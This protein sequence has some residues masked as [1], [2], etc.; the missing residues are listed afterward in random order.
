M[1]IEFIKRLSPYTSVLPIIAKS[2]TLTSQQAS[3]LK[4]SILSELRANGIR[5][6]LFGKSASDILRQTSGDS[7]TAPFAISSAVASDSEN[8][9]ASVLMSADYVPPLVDTELKHLVDAVFDPDHLV[10][11]KHVTAKKY[12]AWRASQL[13]LSTMQSS[14]L[15]SN[16]FNSSPIRRPA[17]PV[18]STTASPALGSPSDSYQLAR[19]ADHTQR[20]ER[21]AKVR[22]SRWAHDLQK[23]LHTEKERYQRLARGERAIWLTE[24]LNECVSDGQIVPISTSK[25]DQRI[26]HGDIVDARDPCGLVKMQETLGQRVLV[27]CKVAGIGGIVGVV[28]V[29]VFRGGAIGHMNDFLFGKAVQG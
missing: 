2:D 9:D 11:L 18:R 8:M 4:L 25:K 3:T 7:P 12:M 6:F 28:G 29:W 24:R 19:I 14:S 22:L 15:L 5:P 1:D 20:E 13:S 16:P 17:T 26:H 27:M 23:S 10:W 21:L